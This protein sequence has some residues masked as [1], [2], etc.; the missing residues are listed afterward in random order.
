VIFCDFV[1]Q[2]RLNWTEKILHIFRV[3]SCTWR[4]VHWNAKYS[5]FRISDAPL[6]LWF[7]CRDT[8]APNQEAEDQVQLIWHGSH[9]GT[10]KKVP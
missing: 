4:K 1:Q 6:S 10:E 5:I 9:I 8:H 3:I 7:S 2:S